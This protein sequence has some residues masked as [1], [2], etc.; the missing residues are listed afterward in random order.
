[1]QAVLHP[2]VRLGIEYDEPPGQRSACGV[3]PSRHGASLHG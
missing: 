2:G 3:D 1:M